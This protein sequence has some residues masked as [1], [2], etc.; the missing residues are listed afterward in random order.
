MVSP[1]LR[2]EKR[3]FLEIVRSRDPGLPGPAKA[4]VPAALH[5]VE[6]SRAEPIAPLPPAPGRWARFWRAP[7]WKFWGALFAMGAGLAV[8]PLGLVLALCLLLEGLR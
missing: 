6:I 2:R 7:F 4:E 1:Y 5:I 3:S 8:L